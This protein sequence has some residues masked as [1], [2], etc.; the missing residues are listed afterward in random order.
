MADCKDCTQ[1]I[2]PYI[3]SSCSLSNIHFD[4]M[5]HNRLD[6]LKCAGFKCYSI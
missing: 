6:K 2:V 3:L 5:S 4:I 1:A